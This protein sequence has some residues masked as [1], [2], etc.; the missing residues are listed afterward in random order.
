MRSTSICIYEHL[1]RE[2]RERCGASKEGAWL[3]KR[4]L[5]KLYLEMMV[6]NRPM[7]IVCLWVCLVIQR[8]VCTAVTFPLLLH[9][10]TWRFISPINDD[11]SSSF[12]HCYRRRLSTRLSLVACKH[13][14]PLNFCC[15]QNSFYALIVHCYHYLHLY[16]LAYHLR[17]L[18][19]L[20]FLLLTFQY[21]TKREDRH[22]S[23]FAVKNKM[24]S[25]EHIAISLSICNSP[26]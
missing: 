12:D 11:A 4:L 26:S 10:C 3:L 5:L 13:F 24:T 2:E 6:M 17:F 19:L 23:R 1:H 20:L 8:A 18:F 15:L 25:L 21:S 7:A 22:N 9:A 16:H 14:T